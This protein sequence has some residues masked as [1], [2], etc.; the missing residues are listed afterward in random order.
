MARPRSGAWPLHIPR[1]CPHSLTPARPGPRERPTT[2]AVPSLSEP[3]LALPPVLELRAHAVG[4]TQA[5]IDIFRERDIFKTKPTISCP[6][7]PQSP[8]PKEERSLG[9]LSGPSAAASPRGGVALG[10]QVV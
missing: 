1:A 2:P 4:A 6:L 9:S 10:L 7:T 5:R 8:H 3:C